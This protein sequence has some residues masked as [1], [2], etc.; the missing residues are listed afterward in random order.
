MLTHPVFEHLYFFLYL[1]LFLEHLM[2]LY[3]FLHGGPVHSSLGQ[4]LDALIPYF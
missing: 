1:S 2:D 4:I 3:S